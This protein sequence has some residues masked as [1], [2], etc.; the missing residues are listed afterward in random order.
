M[1]HLLGEYLC[2]LKCIVRGKDYFFT[3]LK[4]VVVEAPAILGE[5]QVI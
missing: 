1:T 3:A 4:A 2:T 5:F